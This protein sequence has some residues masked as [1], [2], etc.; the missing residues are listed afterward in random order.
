MAEIIAAV[1]SVVYIAFATAT[2]LKKKSFSEAMW[3]MFTT[4]IILGLF[5][6]TIYMSTK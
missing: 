4:G 3:T 5:I 6:A 1:I 2:A